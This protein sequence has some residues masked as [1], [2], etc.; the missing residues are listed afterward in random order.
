MKNYNPTLNHIKLKKIQTSDTSNKHAET[1]T[2]ATLSQN[3]EV[4]FVNPLTLYNFVSWKS[5]INVEVFLTKYESEHKKFKK[6]ENDIVP[7]FNQKSKDALCGIIERINL[8]YKKN[9][10]FKPN[11]YYIS[12]MLATARWEASWGND[13]FCALEERSGGLGKEYFNKYDPVLASTEALRK[14]AKNNGNI[15]EGDG[16]KYRGRGLVHLTWKNNYKKASNY[17]GVDFKTDPD[18]AAELDF[19]VPIMIWGM[20]KGVFT[21]SK[22]PEYI[23][24]NHI[25]YKTA[26]KVINGS[27]SADS[28]A[29][30]AN[31]FESILRQTSNLTEEF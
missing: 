29:S 12:Y 31:L 25:D 19:A 23:Y 28:I 4:W 8:F 14:N 20:M 1:S 21:G 3:G 10:D 15:V 11:I 26:R 16:Y 22:L 9:D 13:F 27:D 5:L 30:F 17:L 6:N 7:N 2:P 18:K 24:K